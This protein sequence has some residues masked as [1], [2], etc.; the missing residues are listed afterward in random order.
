MSNRVNGYFMPRIKF[1]DFPSLNAAW[2]TQGTGVQI[3]GSPQTIPIT[4]FH[5]SAIMHHSIVI[6]E[7]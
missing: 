2:I 3:K 5:Q 7:R 6:T 1:S 4:D